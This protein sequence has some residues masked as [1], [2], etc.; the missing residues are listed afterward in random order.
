MTPAERTQKWRDENPEKARQTRRNYSQSPAGRAGS[1]RKYA[2]TKGRAGSLM[3][4][5][6]VRA[7]KKGLPFDLTTSW[8]KAKID[9]GVCEATGLPLD[10]HPSEGRKNP[11]SPSV[12]RIIPALGYTQA[13]CRV[14]IECSN[15]AR[16]EWGDSILKQLMVALDG[17][18]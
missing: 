3:R 7:N 15:S 16:G 6:R 8:I 17:K 11:F 2:T 5:A 9:A 14:V 13:N 12:D 10:L 1:R 18:L 4:C